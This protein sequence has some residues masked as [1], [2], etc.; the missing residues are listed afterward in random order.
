MRRS[1]RSG[2]SQATGPAGGPP[3]IE[4][5]ALR[6]VYRA[7]GAPEVV[8]LDGVALHVS[9]G[10]VHGLLGPNGA[11]KTTLVKILA[12]VLL[13]TAGTARVLGHD[14]VA[15]TAAVRRLV[16][17]VFGGEQGLYTRLTARQTLRYWATLYRLP[18]GVGR[19]R[20]ELLLERVG[21]AERAD[22]RVE[23]YSRG[24]R[25][26]LHLARGLI[27]DPKV[28]FLDEP[29][30]GMDPVAAQEFRTLL[31]ELRAEGRTI[32]L[33]THDMTEAER[34]CDRVTLI[35]HGRIIAT[36]SPR[37]LGRWISRYERIEVE[38]VDE[39]VLARIQSL[40]GVQ[41]VQ[42][43]PDGLTRIEVGAEGATRAVLHYLAEAGVRSVRTSL[44]TLEEV[45]LEL[46]GDRGLRL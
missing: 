3:A 30:S 16:G 14:V 34:V 32:L 22:D 20:A 17:I 42:V 8:A 38:D 24:M 18:P 4:L 19:Q 9:H 46:V 26:R 5:E 36:E 13:P 33:A 1:T 6:R 35:D 43:G 15:D 28:V 44:P 37:T 2:H 27:G 11:G 41:R 39:E 10:E 31:G 12:T 7:R 40:D 25:Q 23:T 29:T 21:L 45:Y